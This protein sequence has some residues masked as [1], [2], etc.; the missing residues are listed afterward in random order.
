[1][2]PYNNCFYVILHTYREQVEL[3]TEGLEKAKEELLV[4]DKELR[5]AVEV[6]NRVL[7]LLLL[8]MIICLYL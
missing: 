5:E 2:T 4:A 6:C 8:I 1:M 7:R 3:T